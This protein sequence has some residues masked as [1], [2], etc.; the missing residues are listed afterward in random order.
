MRFLLAAAAATLVMS[1]AIAGP[2]PTMGSGNMMGSGATLPDKLA[3]REKTM[4]ARLEQL[5][6]L[7]ATVEPLYAALSDEQKKTADE[8]IFGPMGMGTM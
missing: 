8:L 3:N 2:Q 1:A 4:A 7:K 5:R 6:K